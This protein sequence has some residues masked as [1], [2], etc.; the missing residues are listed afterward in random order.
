MPGIGVMMGFKDVDQE[1]RRDRA[2]QEA[3]EAA[4]AVIRCYERYKGFSRR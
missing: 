1:V 3:L 2:M 4:E